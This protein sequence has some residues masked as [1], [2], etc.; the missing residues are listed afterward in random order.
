MSKFKKIVA[1]V[2]A[3]M[4]S[5]RLPGKVLEDIGGFKSL[6][7]QVK[8]LKR[9]KYI[10]TIILATTENK[11][12]NSLEEF[13]YENKIKV[14]RG[15]E[16]D[17][18]ERILNAAKS[19]DGDL[20]VQITGDCPFIDPQIV[21]QI[22]EYFIEGTSYDFISNEM[23]RSYPIGLD[24][25]VFPVAILSQIDKLCKDPIHRSHGTT[26]IYKGE[27]R[28]IFK[29]KNIFAPKILQ[30]PD[31]RWT[32]DTPKDLTFIKA[33]TS[34]FKENIIEVSAE[35]ITYFLAKHPEI[36]EINKDVIQKDWREG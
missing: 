20:Q 28:K 13:G 23:E 29:N 33:V 3:R 34:Y 8:R 7:C 1:T 18:L 17:I 11:L 21:D 31:W 14:F 6:E 12:D 32:L 9:S 16:D 4:N 35:E 24:C 22:I 25:R 19:V 15:S 10:D 26:Y 5:T 27:G 2:E 36:T 30:N